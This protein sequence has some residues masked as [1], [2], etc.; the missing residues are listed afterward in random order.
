MQVVGEVIASKPAWK[1]RRASEN[2][3]EL[4]QMLAEGMGKWIQARGQGSRGE[5][6]SDC[7]MRNETSGGAVS[8]RQKAAGRTL[9]IG[10]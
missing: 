6:I 7:G 8:G 2:D 3:D 10:E 5:D 4:L 1:R 9:Q